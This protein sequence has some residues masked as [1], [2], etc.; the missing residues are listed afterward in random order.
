MKKSLLLL[1]P[2]LIFA[3]GNL[4]KPAKQY[5]LKRSQNRLVDSQGIERATFRLKVPT[6][7]RTA[8]ERARNFLTSL[9]SSSLKAA[10]SSELKFVKTQQTPRSSHV[11]FS[12][13][14]QNLPVYKSN[15]VVSMNQNNEVSMVMDNRQVG[16]KSI[17]TVPSLSAQTAISVAQNYLGYTTKPSIEP[18]SELMIYNHQGETKLVYKITLVLIS[19]EVQGDFEIVL[20]AQTSD[21]YIA[22]NQIKNHKP[23]DGKQQIKK[24]SAQGQGYVFD[25]DPLSKARKSYGDQGFSDANDSDTNGADSLNNYRTLVT[26]NDLTLENGLYKLK[27]DYVALFDFDS[28]HETFPAFSDPNAFLFTRSEQGFEAV[29]VFYHIDK[30]ARRLEEL[31]FM[32]LKPSAY[33]GG[34]R[35]DPH[36][37]SGADNSTFSPSSDRLIFGE[38]GVDDGED[39]DVIWHEFGHAIQDFT[40]A[41]FE[42]NEGLGEG[43][44]DYWAQSYSRSVTNWTDSDL[45]YHYMFSW[46]GHNNFWSGRTTNLTA[47]YP[48]NLTGDDHH[49]GQLW[50]TPLMQIFDVIGR[51]DMDVLVLASHYYLSSNANQVANAEALLQASEDYFD[52]AYNSIILQTFQSYGQ[53]SGFDQFQPARDLVATAF[54]SRIELR[55]IRPT[56]SPETYA[57]LRGSEE[58]GMYTRIDSG[59]TALRYTDLDVVNDSLYWYKIEARFIGGERTESTPI[60]V[61]PSANFNGKHYLVIQLGNGVSSANSANRIRAAILATGGDVS[62]TSTLPKA[63]ELFVYNAIFVVLGSNTNKYILSSTVF[64]TVFKPY[65]NTGGGMYMEGTDTWFYD[66]TQGGTSA[67]LPY[68]NVS[69]VADD[70]SVSALA[71]VAGEFT[72]DQAFTYTNSDQY[73]DVIAPQ[74]SA[75]TIFTSNGGSTARVIANRG[76][77][78]RTI[79]SSVGFA[80]FVDAALPNTRTI[81]MSRYLSFFAENP[82][83][84]AKLS[85]SK[86]SLISDGISADNYSTEFSFSNVGRDSLLTYTIDVVLD[87]SQET[88]LFLPFVKSG[89]LNLLE[90]RTVLAQFNPAFTYGVYT[91]HFLIR[92]NDPV[93]SIQI[94]PFRFYPHGAYQISQLSQLPDRTIDQFDSTVVSINLDTVFSFNGFSAIDYT[95]TQSD[96]SVVEL[97]LMNSVLHLVPKAPIGESQI[98]ITASVDTFSIH[99]DFT[100]RRLDITPP[101]VSLHYD[102]ITGDSLRIRAN[103]SEVLAEEP[104]LVLGTDSFSMSF[105]NMANFSYESTYFVDRSDEI[106]FRLRAHDPS[107]NKIDTAETFIL[108]TEQTLKKP[109]NLHDVLHVSWP[110][111]QGQAVF[112]RLTDVVGSQLNSRFSPLTKA[113]NIQ[114]RTSDAITFL[115]NPSKSKEQA[116]LYQKLNTQWLFFS[117]A[118]KI[119][120]QAAGEYALIQNLDFVYLPTEPELFQNYPNPF[121]P[122]TTIKFYLNAEARVKLSIYNSVGQK[123]RTLLNSYLPQQ[124]HLVEWHGENDQGQQVS[125]G[126]YF[127]VLQIND[128]QIVKKMLLLK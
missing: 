29:N 58:N 57:I 97:S 126:I 112:I 16:L 111:P 120:I 61:I 50:S 22:E 78:Y 74:N 2:L 105:L 96:S 34:I 110:L 82:E 102:W 24:T 80:G 100:Y 94:K 116:A 46:D 55:W 86:D 67:H 21:I 14:V 117:A 99:T 101:Q 6:Q 65:L 35:C 63:D 87:Q 75:F 72:A 69:G 124:R 51:E 119:H 43:F 15:I 48:E 30:A 98:Q 32:G 68:F 113:L 71:G 107:S 36:G 17:S 81:L 53:L 93:D 10:G 25:P 89:T 114:L 9:A 28:P 115:F 106:A 90:S 20:D 118:K 123:V 122:N 1:V 121:N 19:S 44:S 127:Y 4:L 38:G 77:N 125:S 49:D 83:G 40:V 31:G 79:A 95:F 45:Q 70:V 103:F 76:V 85:L 33:S 66:P 52:G 64:S 84:F 56:L 104:W 62:I 92:S 41:G 37:H 128:R 13:Y 73:L 5:N 27:N 109:Y 47:H 42:G 59:L 11:R 8:E 54:D 39:A 3:Q 23:S 60:G 88:T 12:Q 91:G 18:K 26:L 108:I 7:G